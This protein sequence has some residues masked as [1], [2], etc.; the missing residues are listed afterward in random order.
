MSDTE[1]TISALSSLGSNDRQCAYGIFLNILASQHQMYFGQVV[2]PADAR[3]NTKWQAAITVNGRTYRSDA[4]TQG[5]MEALHLAA[6][7]ALREF[8]YP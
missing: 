8:G 1:S 3:R 2:E 6:G 4:Y 5:K 7:K